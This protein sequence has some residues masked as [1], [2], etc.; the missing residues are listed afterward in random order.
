MGAVSTSET[1]SFYQ[2]TMR[3]KTS[4]TVDQDH[5]TFFFPRTNDNYCFRPK[6][7]GSPPVII[8]KLIASF[9]LALVI[10]IQNWKIVILHA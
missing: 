7:Q 10:P 5:P 2:T 9:P 3:R 8:L 1:V 4:V 6:G